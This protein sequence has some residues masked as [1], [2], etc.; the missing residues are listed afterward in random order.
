MVRRERWT[1]ADPL[2]AL[3]S[4]LGPTGLSKDGLPP[5][6][7]GAVGYLSFECAAYFEKLPLGPRVEPEVPE[8]LFML[9]DPVLVFDHVLRLARVI[10]TVTADEPG[11]VDASYAAAI[12][13][14]DAVCSALAR[15]AS[16][17]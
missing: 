9:A 11:G 14:I 16:G 2:V 12:T 3:Q 5:F 8:A 17:A 6:C 1:C 15:T 7:G 4:L 10:S 13:R